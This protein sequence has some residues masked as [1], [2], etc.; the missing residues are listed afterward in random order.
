MRE[1]ASSNVLEAPCPESSCPAASE[2][3]IRRLVW[4]KCGIARC[5][6]ELL[7]AC[8][9]LQARQLQRKPEALLADYEVRNLH[10]VGLLI[11]RCAWH[12]EESRGAHFRTDF[13]EKRPEWARHSVVSRSGEI[14]FR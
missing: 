7:E 1:W 11:A 13:P 6:P 12:R 2:D 10:A 9:W 3:Q 8:N 4:E 5:G 14:S